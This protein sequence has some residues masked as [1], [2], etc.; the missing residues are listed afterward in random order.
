MP[1]VFE[2]FRR[3]LLERD[4]LERYAEESDPGS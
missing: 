3:V 1:K 2:V 4:A